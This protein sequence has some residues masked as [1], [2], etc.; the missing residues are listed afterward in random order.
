MQD[1]C[2]NSCIVHHIPTMINPRSKIAVEGLPYIGISV[3]FA[4]ITALFD[5]NV[6]SLL[7]AVTA[8]FILYFFRD[9][10]RET[11]KD[12]Y[13][14]IAPAD[15]RVVA[16]DEIS[17]ESFLNRE[18]TRI[19]IFLSITDCHINRFPV[20]G[21]VIATKFIPGRFHKAYLNLASTENERLATL[22]ETEDKEQIVIVQIAGIIARRIVSYL[23][24]GDLLQ[25]GERFGM[26]KF[27]SRV[28][29][30]L[31]LRCEV[32]VGVE[33][34]VRGGETIVGWLKEREI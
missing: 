32:A 11:P 5:F 20:T 7:L 6:L 34:K 33:D 19:S 10:E 29:L 16:I 8:G 27:G 23:T 31:P 2:M 28:D 24:L 15:G 26:I 21:K 18:M 30:Y 4:W 17:E 14:V 12:P 25:K 9:P 13:A 3:F 1:L 22:V